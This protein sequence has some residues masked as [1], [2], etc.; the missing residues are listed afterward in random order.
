MLTMADWFDALP[1]LAV[2]VPVRDS[3]DQCISRNESAEAKP[4]VE[5][6]ERYH[7]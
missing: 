5:V 2:E 3:S 4:D 1:R 7:P 6:E